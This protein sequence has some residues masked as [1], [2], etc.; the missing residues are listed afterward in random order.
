MKFSIRDLFWLT[1]VAAFAI[2]WWIDRGRL[3]RLQDEVQQREQQEQLLVSSLWSSIVSQSAGPS[4]S[5]TQPTQILDK[6]VDEA[7]ERFY[8]NT[9]PEL[10]PD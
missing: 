4:N 5:R 8:Q 7:G 2:L 9:P 1:L 6:I 10:Q 3:H